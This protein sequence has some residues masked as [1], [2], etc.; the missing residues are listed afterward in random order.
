MDS[1]LAWWVWLLAGIGTGLIPVLGTT[2]IV[3][4]LQAALVIGMPFYIFSTVG[5]AWLP[6]VFFYGGL[7][8]ISSILFTRKTKREA[9][10]REDSLAAK[11][12]RWGTSR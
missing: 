6:F 9:Q 3:G 10:S 12:K 5:G 4:F 2:R 7:A 11:K 1:N 8:V